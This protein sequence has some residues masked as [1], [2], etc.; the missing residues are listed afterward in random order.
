MLNYMLLL[1]SSFS[2]IS[3]VVKRTLKLSPP[4][5]FSVVLFHSKSRIWKKCKCL[6]LT[7]QQPICIFISTSHSSFPPPFSSSFPPHISPPPPFH[8]PSACRC[9]DEFCWMN[10]CLQGHIFTRNKILSPYWNSIQ[11]LERFKPPNE[12]ITVIKPK[13]VGKYDQSQC[14]SPRITIGYLQNSFNFPGVSWV[15][16]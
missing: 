16:I 9:M 6:L 5:L 4:P 2:S 7:Y 8:F 14:K 1:T 15:K 12:S 3:K 13:T 10:E 11:Y